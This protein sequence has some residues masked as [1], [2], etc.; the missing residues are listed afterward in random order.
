MDLVAD[1]AGHRP[2]R[3][4]RVNFIQPDQFPYTTLSGEHYDTGEYEKPLNRALELI[5]Y[6][7]LRK[8][9]AELRKQG[10]YLGIGLASY[11]EICGFGPWESSTVRVEPG[12]EVTI[13][14]GISPHG[15][16]QET[17][18]A[19]TRRRLY[20]RRFR[21]GDRPPWRHRQHGAR[22]RHGGQPRSRGRRRRAGASH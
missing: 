4:R 22:Q 21:Q 17:T 15:Q 10:R 12:G 19:Q 20:R 1:E 8:E 7:R 2:D 6:R 16:G 5:D 13:F 14:T 3:V 18:F 9:Q 11:V